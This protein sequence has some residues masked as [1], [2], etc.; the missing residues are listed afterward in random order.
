MTPR[1]AVLAAARALAPRG[2]AVSVGRSGSTVVVTVSATVR[3]PLPGGPTVPVRA[4]AVA[5]AEQIP[6][7]PDRPAS[8]GRRRER[9]AGSVLVLGAVLVAAAFAV[10]AAGL[11][12]ALAARHR[13]DAAADLAALAAAAAWPQPDCGRAASVAAANGAALVGCSVVGEGVV[14]VRVSVPVPA[15]W[16][17]VGAAGVVARA[18]PARAGCARRR[19]RRQAG[20]AAPADLVGGRVPQ[21]EVQQVQGAGLVQR[22]VPVAALGGLHARRAAVRRTRSRETACRVARSHV[23]AHR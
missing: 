20:A 16:S 13:A 14:E 21:H 2:A 7:T 1:A 12:Q 11:V 4:R 15:P 9:G 23:R 22:L 5:D 17:V 6:V 3:V 8:P 10:G 19:R 18:G